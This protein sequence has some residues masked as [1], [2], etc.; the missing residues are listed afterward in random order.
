MWIA[1]RKS[2]ASIQ[3]K[4]MVPVTQNYIDK[5][6]KFIY[7]SEEMFIS[8]GNRENLER[9]VGILASLYQQT[10]DES[11]IIDA[12]AILNVTAAEMKEIFDNFNSENS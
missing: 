2:Y 8:H 9:S 5:T 4:V 12:A 3:G 1:W 10:Q 11:L 7:I 6:G